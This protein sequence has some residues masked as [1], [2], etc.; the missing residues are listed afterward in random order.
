MRNFLI[1]TIALLLTAPAFATDD[2]AVRDFLLQSPN[3]MNGPPS[4]VNVRFRRVRNVQ[5]P[6]TLELTPDCAAEVNCP[7]Q[8]LRVRRRRRF[9]S[10]ENAAI[11]E[12]AASSYQKRYFATLTDASGKR[13]SRS[14]VLRCFS[15]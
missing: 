6:V 5:F 1:I 2:L 14:V 13:T 3:W 11:C 10:F 15:R 12:E 8:T 4:A 9:I 7:A